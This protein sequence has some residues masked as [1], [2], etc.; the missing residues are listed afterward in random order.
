MNR[1]SAGSPG[2]LDDLL[3]SQI[4]LLGRRR[5]EMNG[6]AG[7]SDMRRI[8]VSVGIDGDRLDSHRMTGAHHAQR[9]LAAI[10]D[11]NFAKRLCPHLSSTVRNTSALCTRRRLCPHPDE[12]EKFSQALRA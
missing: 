4:R 5:A 9:D 8:S 1:V 2:G 10:G 12:P 3:D 11:Q 6:L 7:E